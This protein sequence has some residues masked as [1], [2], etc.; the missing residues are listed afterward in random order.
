MNSNS[1]NSLYGTDNPFICILPFSYAT[2]WW[3]FSSKYV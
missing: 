2:W 1:N 3:H